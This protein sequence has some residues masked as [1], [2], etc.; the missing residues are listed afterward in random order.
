MFQ[1]LYNSCTHYISIPCI[2]YTC[3]KYN[4]SSVMVCDYVVLLFALAAVCAGR[5]S[6]IINGKDVNPPGKYPWQ[7]SLQKDERHICGGSVINDRWFLTAAH[8]V[9]GQVSSGMSVVLGLHDQRQRV[10]SPKRYGITKIYSHERYQQ[11]S[12]TFPNDI[13]LIHLNQVIEMNNK[14]QPIDLDRH[15]EFNGNS[16]CVISGWG[17]T[18]AASSASGSGNTAANILQETSTKIISNSECAQ[19]MG[20]SSIYAGHVCVK[21]GTSGAC[22]GDSGGPLHCRNNGGKFTLVGATSWGSRSCATNG[23]SMYTRVSYFIGWID[24]TIE[25]YSDDAGTGEGTGGTGGG[26]N[27]SDKYKNCSFYS[28]MCYNPTVKQQC[29]QTCA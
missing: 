2:Q 7:G 13:A 22:M 25:N 6:N 23:P 15:G 5:S 26:A 16:D 1:P 27:C 11:G 19:Y 24:R 29:C 18:N 8:C 14:V 4:S 20:A 28:T 12:G 10:G 9:E 21:T 17:Y 3:I